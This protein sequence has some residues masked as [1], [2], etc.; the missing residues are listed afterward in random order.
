METTNN[1]IIEAFNYYTSN[2]KV[3]ENK[4]LLRTEML[5]LFSNKFFCVDFILKYGSYNDIQFR[6]FSTKSQMIEYQQTKDGCEESKYSCSSYFS[7]G[8]KNWYYIHC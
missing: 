2:F 4:E 6:I 3:L 1:A 5:D 7:D 8:T